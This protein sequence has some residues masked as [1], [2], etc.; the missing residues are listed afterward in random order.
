MIHIY[1]E[2][3]KPGIRFDIHLFHLFASDLDASEPAEAVDVGNGVGHK[4]RESCER[5]VRAHSVSYVPS[6]SNVQAE[7][8]LNKAHTLSKRPA[9]KNLSMTK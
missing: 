4:K 6:Q 7:R 1:P 2:Q 8:L 9:H 3:K 5:D